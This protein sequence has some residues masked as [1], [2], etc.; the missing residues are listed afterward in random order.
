M[1][2]RKKLAESKKQKVMTFGKKKHAIAVVTCNKGKGLVKCNGVPIDLLQPEPLRLKVM[3]PILIAGKHRFRNVDM[4]IRVRGG[5]Q[6]SQLYAVRQAIAKALVAYYQ[7][8]VD[9]AQK[10]EI[11]D[12]YLQ[13]D[14]TL[15]VADPRRTEPKKFGG[16]GARARRT[17][18]YR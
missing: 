5:G 11:K 17:K 12:A 1:A 9:E 8:Y 2:D 13:Y 10:L 7:K 14:R 15:L 3:E 4:R 16:H 6:T 18:S